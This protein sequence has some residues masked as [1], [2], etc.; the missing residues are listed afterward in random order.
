MERRDI[1]A[2]GEYIGQVINIIGGLRSSLDMEVPGG[3]PGQLDSLYEYMQ[4]R[5]L[6]ASH[7]NDPDKLHQVAELLNTLKSGWDGIAP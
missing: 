7:H 1:P 6:E 4:L 3:L 5:L 2:K